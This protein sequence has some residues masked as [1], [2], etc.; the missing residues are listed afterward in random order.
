MLSQARPLGRPSAAAA[1]F[2]TMG[3]SD[4]EVDQAIA[5]NKE[6]RLKPKGKAAPKKPAACTRKEK[7]KVNVKKKAGKKDDDEDIEDDNDD[8]QDDDVKVKKEVQPGTWSVRK[9]FPKSNIRRWTTPGPRFAK[10]VA[11]PSKEAVCLAKMELEMKELPKPTPTS[12]SGK[13]C[14]KED[15]KPQEETKAPKRRHRTKSARVLL[16]FFYK[17]V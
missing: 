14:E 9:E 3:L 17:L 12:T 2:T 6:G 7:A 5:L 10:L 13:D 8:S 1:G 4:A 16:A 11:M 15:E